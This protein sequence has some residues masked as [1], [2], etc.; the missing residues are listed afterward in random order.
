MSVVPAQRVGLPEIRAAAGRMAGF[1]IRTPLLEAAELSERTGGKLRLKVESVQ[2]SGSFKFRGAFN[3]LARRPDD[4]IAPGVIT[5]SSGNHGQAV[6]LAAKLRGVPATVVMPVTAPAVKREGAERLGARVVLEGT[7]SI[8][9]KT[10]AEA[11][12]AEGGLCMVPPFDHLDIIAGQ[13]TVGL[14][15]AEEWPEVDTWVV[16]IGGGGL[17]SGSAAALR[18]LRP[19]IRIIGVEPEGASAMRASLDAGEPV[20]LDRID[21]IADGLAP[22]R[23]GDLTFAHVQAL[24]DDVV[25][26]TDD[27]IRD[28]TRFLIHRQKLIVEYSGAAPTAAVLSG[29]VD[30]TGRRVAAVISG[31]N[32]DSGILRELL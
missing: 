24:F 32:L 20:T 30:C 23:P 7:T 2:R 18:A 21:T 27:E 9:R 10:R 26:V 8:D 17:A 22:V 29:K 3:F 19:G 1:A 12:Q 6:A 25:T 14:E 4:V 15:V 16:C 5:Y 11:I 31:G 28:A 13:G